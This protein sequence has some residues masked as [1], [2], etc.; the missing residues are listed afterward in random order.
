[1]KVIRLA[2]ENV[3]RLVAV[4]ITPT[5]HLVM[6]GGKNGAGKSSV[7]NALAM[8]LGGTDLCPSVPIRGKELE[9]KVFVDLGDLLITRTF[10][11]EWV[12]DVPGT[13]DS[14]KFLSDVTSTLV[15]KSKD[16]A[17]YPS[18]QT[19]LNKLLG[20][21]T[22]DPLA[23]KDMKPKPQDEMLRKLVGLDV[24][25]LEEA[26][27]EAYSQ[28]ALSKKAHD[29]RLSQLIALPSHKDVPAEELSM[30]GPTSELARAGELR[31]VADDADRK[32]TPAR[33]AVS[34]KES[35][36]AQHLTR[37]D[38]LEKQI[39]QLQDQ[40]KRHEVSVEEI[41][42]ALVDARQHVAAC[43]KASAA[44]HDAIPDTRIITNKIAEINATNIKVREN[45]RYNEL[46]ADVERISAQIN[47]Q[48]ALVR[49]AEDEKRAA[50][51]KV[52][53][54]VTGLGLNDEGVTFNDL[55]FA[56]ASTAEQLRV[57]V[58]IGLALNPRLKVLLIRS[59]NLLDDDSLALV[60][61]Q[62]A[63][64]DAQ[65]WMEYVTNDAADVQVMIEDG[66]IAQ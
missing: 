21:L 6:I 9:A 58:A 22:F 57:S 18:P 15:V 5:G 12:E 13:S 37:V 17:I 29:T 7:L 26:R 41:D 59:G 47:E 61:Q 51:A 45:L 56:Q 55:P 25:Q 40:V 24:S 34:L 42:V 53:F 19:M 44:A 65:V 62:A 3:M 64:A 54:P 10:K 23:F 66:R 39:L 2:S 35:T 52:T 8:A 38:E 4:D 32:L 30:D 60:A 63:D 11:R 33:A 36:R 1:M 49:R 46:A 28:R 20:A 50:L 16:G 43:S 48:D 31:R 27:K 14:K